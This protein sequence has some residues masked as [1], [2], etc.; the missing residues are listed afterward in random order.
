MWVN[1]HPFNRGHNEKAAITQHITLNR[2]SVSKEKST[3][4]HSV[5]RDPNLKKTK[6]YEKIEHKSA[7]RKRDER[8]QSSQ[9]KIYVR[10]RK[11]RT[12][13]LWDLFL[14][15]KHILKVIPK[16]CLKNFLTSC[17][18]EITVDTCCSCSKK[19]KII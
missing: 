17:K 12:N 18:I 1:T 15:K 5:A 8:L 19:N 10:R 2:L 16:L 4:T 7:G 6:C 13:I 9:Q 3:V 14:M 11:N